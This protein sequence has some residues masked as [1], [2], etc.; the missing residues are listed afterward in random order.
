MINSNQLS[1]ITSEEDLESKKNTRRSV[2]DYEEEQQ[3]GAWSKAAALKSPRIRTS[4][5]DSKESRESSIGA[6]PDAPQYDPT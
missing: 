6:R 3:T 4:S 5:K 2:K 1:R